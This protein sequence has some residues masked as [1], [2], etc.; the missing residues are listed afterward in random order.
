MVRMAKRR[1]T[2]TALSEED[3]N[4]LLYVLGIT[5]RAASPRKPG[6]ATFWDAARAQ[7]LASYFAKLADELHARR[8]A[9]AGNVVTLE[10]KRGRS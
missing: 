8:V 10:P 9:A 2:P 7:I 1:A 3:R 6:P 5:T 4:L